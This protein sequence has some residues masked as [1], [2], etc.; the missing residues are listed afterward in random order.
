MYLSKFVREKL[1]LI[2]PDSFPWSLLS[3]KGIK[4]HNEGKKKTSSLNIVIKVHQIRVCE[5]VDVI[6][7]IWHV[8]LFPGIVY[9]SQNNLTTTLVVR[10]HRAKFIDESFEGVGDDPVFGEVLEHIVCDFLRQHSKFIKF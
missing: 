7:D 1:G 9:V 10:G 5:T 3:V 8:A 6:V 2:F 4:F